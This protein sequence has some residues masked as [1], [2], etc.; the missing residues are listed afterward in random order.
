M[1]LALVH[2][3]PETRRVVGVWLDSD[4]HAYLRTKDGGAAETVGREVVASRGAAVTWDEWV[5]AQV[6]TSP[7]VALF[8]SASRSPEDE[9]RHVLARAVAQESVSLRKKRA[10]EG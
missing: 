9:P 10:S 2:L 6:K 4:R 5:R 3:H 7:T 1:P 8:E